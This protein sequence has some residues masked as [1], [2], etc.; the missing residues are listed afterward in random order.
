MTFEGETC[1]AAQSSDFAAWRERLVSGT[2]ASTSAPAAA[3]AAA[4]DG[5][6]TAAVAD[7]SSG[8]S[9][10]LS[11]LGGVARVPAEYHF[12]CQVRGRPGV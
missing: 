9:V 3:A 11:P 8:D 6:G 10:P 12:V 2:T 7:G 5:D 4:E 1:I